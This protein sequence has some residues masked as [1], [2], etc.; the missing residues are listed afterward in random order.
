VNARDLALKAA[1]FDAAGAGLEIRHA[2][3]EPALANPAAGAGVGPLGAETRVE[4]LVEGRARLVEA[5]SFTFEGRDYR[6]LA[7]LDVDAQRRVQDD[8]FLRAYFDAATGLPNRELCDRTIADMIAARDARQPFAVAILAVDRF[9]EILALHGQSACEALM[10]RIGERLNALAA[11]H[12]LVAK[13]AG[14]E[15]AVIVAE[16]GDTQALLAGCRRFAERAGE[17]CLVEG[18]EIFASVAAGACVWP[19]GGD[20]AE[21][22]RRKARAAAREALRTMSGAR[23]FS[24]DIDERERQRARAD[25][26]LRQAIRDRRIGCA[27]QPKVDFRSGEIDS[28]EVLMRWLGEDGTWS[29]PG[30]FLDIAHEVGLTNEITALVFE[31]TMASLDAINEAFGR[32]PKLGFNIAARQ[33]CDTRFM[34]GFLDMLERSGHAPRFMLEITEEAFLPGGHFQSR[35]LP[36]IREVGAHISIDDFGS[37][38]SSLAT[39]A[40]ITADEVKVDRSLITDIDKKP[41]SQSLLRAIE[42]IGEAL[43]TEVI[44]EGVETEAEFCYLRDHTRIRVAQGYYFGRPVMLSG[45]EGGVAWREKRASASNRGSAR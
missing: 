40:D 27:F 1:A 18:V 38:Y 29:T 25:N 26:A 10:A 41:R 23:L 34:R 31:E 24:S 12:D 17:P 20:G 39:L 21:A 30:N 45:V 42:S 11:P 5:R 35:I 6:V 16:P 14:D 37:G 28:L 22:L 13:L 33:A 8:L 32:E 44:V 15:F 2:G 43:S 7:S 3:G 19:A 4:R 36:M 9:T